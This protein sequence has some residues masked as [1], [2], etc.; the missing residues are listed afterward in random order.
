VELAVSRDLRDWKRVANRD[1]FLGVQP[2]DGETYDTAQ[3]LTCGRPVVREDLGE[4]WVYYNAC[5][6]RSWRDQHDESYAEYFEDVNAVSLAKVRLDGFVSLDA[7]KKGT[8]VTAPFTL[9]GGDLRV[10]VE[11][12]RGELRAEVL[13]AET[14]E[15][16]PGLS[17]ADCDA[18]RGDELRGRLTWNGAGASAR[19]RPVRL[20]FEMSQTKLYAFWLE[21]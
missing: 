16:L 5:R 7:E 3:L 4:I 8:L 15:P 20:R 14:M 18:A 13:D 11:A 9:D 17:V 6:F 19:E 2:W 21:G 12:Q 10:N 1:V